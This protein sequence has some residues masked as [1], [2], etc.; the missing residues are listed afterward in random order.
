MKRSAR[1]SAYIATG[2]AAGLVLALILIAFL[3]RSDWGMQRVRGIAL[4]WLKDR[5]QGEVRIGR[6]TG[7][8]LLNGA[9]LHDVSIV[10]KNK[11]PFFTVDSA[12]VSYDWKTLI[13]GSIELKH[14]RMFQPR[15]HLEQIPGDTAWNY[16]FIFEDT[17]SKKNPRTRR[18]IMFDD[19]QIVRG[20]ASVMFP[21]KPPIMPGDTARM[22]TE[23]FGR[24][25]VRR[26]HFDSINGHLDRALWETPLETGKLFD[27]SKVSALAYVYRL[28]VKVTDARGKVA[29]RDTIVTLDFPDVRLPS[30]HGSVFG[31]V[32]MEEGRNRFDIQLDFDNFAFR[33][34]GW[35]YDR[36]PEQ[37][38]GRGRMRIQSLPNGTLFLAENARLTTP[39]TNVAG[40][41]GI[42]VGDTVYFTK[43]D[44]RASPLDIKVIKRMLP[45]GLPIDGLLMGT[46]EL[47][48]PLS[49]N[50]G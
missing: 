41:F 18:L 34:M 17:A 12:E 30:S 47:K 20:G 23:R 13:G 46:V 38:G 2:I 43:V 44:L 35:L 25:L 7:G 32:I 9:I 6:I 24:G 42:V 40:T 50:G 14:V 19:V 21:V 29:L 15:V 16:Q 33:D 27:V 28:P 10:G 4:G 48:G 1:L 31:R 8:G 37:G 39:G 22:S 3:T 26:M 45:N 11:R 36:L 5:V 49:G